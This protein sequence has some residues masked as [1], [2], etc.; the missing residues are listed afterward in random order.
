M[1]N[2]YEA[3][4]AVAETSPGY[5][6]NTKV[7]KNGRTRRTKRKPPHED[8]G[9]TADIEQDLQKLATEVALLSCDECYTD[10]AKDESAA[11]YMG[12]PRYIQLVDPVH[13]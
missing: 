2:I 10:T 7:K 11:R 5:R 4:R 3:Y 9:N 6:S 13:V 8:D 1:D 12:P